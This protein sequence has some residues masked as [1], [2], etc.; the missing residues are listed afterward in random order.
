MSVVSLKLTSVVQRLCR[1][2]T[3]P[4]L[5]RCFAT[6]NRS[7]RRHH[8]LVHHSPPY[9]TNTLSQDIQGNE[10]A[11]NIYKELAFSHYL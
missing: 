9:L 6:G 3:P 1:N 11:V 7:P 5:H 8:L 10:P 4:V 2:I